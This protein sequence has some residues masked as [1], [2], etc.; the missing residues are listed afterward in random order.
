M[1]CSAEHGE[2]KRM[3][4]L[5]RIL[6]AFEEFAALFVDKDARFIDCRPTEQSMHINVQLQ[7][8]LSSGKAGAFN[9]S[10]VRRKNRRSWAASSPSSSV[11]LSLPRGNTDSGARERE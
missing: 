6:E 5:H 2:G 3:L 1:Q 8:A 7:C 9:I 11:R 10:F 4:A